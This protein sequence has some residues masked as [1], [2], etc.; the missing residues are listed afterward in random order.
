[1]FI[2]FWFNFS[3]LFWGEIRSCTVH[4]DSTES[5]ALPSSAN[6]TLCLCRMEFWVQY[7]FLSLLVLDMWILSVTV[8]R[9]IDSLSDLFLQ[10]QH[11]SGKRKYL[12]FTAWFDTEDFLFGWN[13]FL[14]SA[15]EQTMG[16]SKYFYTSFFKKINFYTS[17]SYLIFSRIS[18]DLKCIRFPFY[19]WF[20]DGNARVYPENS[21]DDEKWKAICITRW[22]HYP[23]LGNQ[24]LDVYA[25][26]ICKNH[27]FS[28]VN[29]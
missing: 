20:E 9:V 29:F 21:P 22:P 11:I 7:W 15:S 25:C 13:M 1:M 2:L 6:W 12:I 19:F 27:E 23:F 10:L 24:I 4:K 16:H 8:G 14:E 18:V 5:R 26:N 17:L 28:V 3:V